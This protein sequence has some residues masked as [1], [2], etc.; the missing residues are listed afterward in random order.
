MARVSLRA[1]TPR[2]VPRLV[3]DG[4]LGGGLPPG[5][6]WDHYL[7]GPIAEMAAARRLVLVAEFDGKLVGMGQLVFRFAPGYED[8]EAAN[9]ADIGMVEMVRALPNPPNLANFIIG[10]LERYARKHRIRTLTFLVPMDNNNKGL[11]QVKSWGFEEF[12]IMPKGAQLL[13][14]YRKK[15][16]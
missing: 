2:D 5:E 3:K 10:E 4:V 9:G 1:C 16:G 13:A 7:A 14:F 15:I 8:L 11:A 12:R 6:T